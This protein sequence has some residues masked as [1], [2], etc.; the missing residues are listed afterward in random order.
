MRAAGARAGLWKELKSTLPCRTTNGY[1]MCSK[2]VPPDNSSV[3]LQC[4]F[5]SNTEWFHLLHLE[6]CNFWAQRSE[7]VDRLEKVQRTTRLL[8]RLQNS[9]QAEVTRTATYS[10]C[11]R[12]FLYPLEAEISGIKLILGFSFWQT[13]DTSEIWWLWP[14]VK[15]SNNWSNAWR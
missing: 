6:A 8:T 2:M 14:G 5:I 12:I 15:I 4:D 3:T 1:S 9:F 11:Y 7:H 10:S 13:R